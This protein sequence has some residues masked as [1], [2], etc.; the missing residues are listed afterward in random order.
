VAEG[1][2]YAVNFTQGGQH[3]VKVIN[4]SLGSE[5]RARP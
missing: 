3:P 2:D 1:V 4:L 5:S